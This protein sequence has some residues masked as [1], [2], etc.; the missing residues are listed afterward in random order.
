MEVGSAINSKF[1]NFNKLLTE[2]LRILKMETDPSS[3]LFGYY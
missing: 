1:N 3:F 2:F